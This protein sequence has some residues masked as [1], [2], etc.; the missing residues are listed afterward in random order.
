MPHGAQG[1]ARCPYTT[2]FRSIVLADPSAGIYKKL[3]LRDDKLVG[4][5]LYGD[6]VDGAW[7]FKLLREGTNIGPLRDRLMFGESN[8]SEEHTSELQSQFHLVCRLLLEKI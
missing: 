1:R 6:T 7:Y 4:A 3:V 2:L 5:V 8:R